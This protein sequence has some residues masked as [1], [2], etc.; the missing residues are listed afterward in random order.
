MPETMK[1]ERRFTPHRL[2]IRAEGGGTTAGNRLEGYAAKFNLESLVICDDDI[3]DDEG[4]PIPFVE[5]IAP[6]AFARTLKERPDVRALFNHDT[7]AVLG[8]TKSGTLTLAED[9]VGLAFA[10]NLPDTQV[11]RDVKVSVGR[12]D[13]D[14]CSFGFVVIDATLELRPAKPA[15]RTLLDVELIE[16]TPAVTFPAYE[17]TEVYL[18]S[19]KTRAVPTPKTRPRFEQARRLLQ[20]EG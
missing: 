20:I 5:V 19:L 12:G 6:G 10:C 11:G 3:C 7:S 1:V 16:I 13:I 18:R 14:G 15:V 2:E 9:E 17:D 4:D 8:R